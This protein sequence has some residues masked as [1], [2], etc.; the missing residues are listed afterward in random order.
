MPFAAAFLDACNWSNASSALRTSH[1]I[2][3]NRRANV[4]ERPVRIY[5]VGIVG[6]GKI[7]LD[8]HLPSIAQTGLF[9]PAALVS[10]RGIRQPG[11][12]TFRTQTE[13]LAAL[14]DLDAVAIC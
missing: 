14:S 9:E 10:Q 13:M 8:Q 6:V 1:H 7:A 2:Q 12:P 4:E 5:T 11:I 3:V